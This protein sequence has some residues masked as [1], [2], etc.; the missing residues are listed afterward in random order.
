MEITKIIGVGIIGTFFAITV[1]SYRKELGMGVSAAAGIVIFAMVIPQLG[2]AI[3]KLSALCEESG[4][5]IEYF[6]V[7]IKI[8][9]IAYIT[10]FGAELAKDAGEGA[11]AKKIEFAGKVSVITI[12]L[13]IVEN[14]LDVI[15]STLM[16]F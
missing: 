1:R 7:I 10:Q 13:P 4:I 9:G 16:S 6:K 5:D 3:R 8:I 15:I 2:E 11:V 12:M 14:L